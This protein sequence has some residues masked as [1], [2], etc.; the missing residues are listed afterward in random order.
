MARTLRRF[1]IPGALILFLQIP[2][3]SSA[4]A[5]G[6]CLGSSTARNFAVYLHGLEDP[7][8]RS[9][10][11][12]E[13]REIL[14]RLAQELPLRVALP[15][16]PLC[17][18]GKYCW[19]ASDPNEVRKTFAALLTQVESCWSG[20]PELTLIGFSNGGYFAWKLYKAH[21]APQ[22]KRIVA[23]GSTGVWDSKQDRINDYASFHLMMGQKDITLK[24][25]QSFAQALRRVLPN[26]TFDTFAGGHRLDYE[27]LLK[28]LRRPLPK[29]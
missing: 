11:E 8:A 13:N 10:E 18:M 21:Q 9:E 24:K 29:K 4:F 20:T 16:G 1:Q 27:T 15:R 19:P 5:A 7:Q 26:F 2:A 3:F 17:A 12:L 28:I 25:A 23:V 22:L 14:Q 6:E